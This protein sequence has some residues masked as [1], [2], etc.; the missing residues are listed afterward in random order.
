MSKAIFAIF[1]GFFYEKFEKNSKNACKG[2]TGVLE[3]WPSGTKW[4]DLEQKGKEVDV[5]VLW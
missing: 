4:S 3:W 5:N 2:W 1:S